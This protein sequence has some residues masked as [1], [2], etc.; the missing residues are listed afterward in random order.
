MEKTWRGDMCTGILSTKRAK[1]KLTL[2]ADHISI[3]GPLGKIA[4]PSENVTGITKAGWFPWFWQG[5]RIL[6]TDENSPQT[7]KFAATNFKSKEILKEAAELGYQ[8]IG[9]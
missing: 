6:H 1:A 4:L 9:N 2:S 7:V 8:V 3:T 5:I